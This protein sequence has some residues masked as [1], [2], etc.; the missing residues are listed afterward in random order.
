MTPQEKA[1]ELL[2]K[3]LRIEDK[4]TFYWEPYYDRRCLDEEV[5]DH[6]KKCALITID[7]IVSACEY[8]NVESLNTDWWNKVRISLNAL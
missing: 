4:T 2:E 5:K 6:A 3:Y 8:N 7:E 1:K